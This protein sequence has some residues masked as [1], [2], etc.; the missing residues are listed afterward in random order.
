MPTCTYPVVLSRAMLA[1]VIP[2]MTFDE[3][4]Q[5]VLPTPTNGY[6]CPICT[7]QMT[8]RRRKKDQ[9]AFYG[10][11]NWPD[12]AGTRELNG[13]IPK[14]YKGVANYYFDDCDISASSRRTHFK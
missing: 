5:D 9:K 1:R 13:A 10:C 12:C 6:K 4:T 8:F 11:L 7:T 3:L 2:D 14:A